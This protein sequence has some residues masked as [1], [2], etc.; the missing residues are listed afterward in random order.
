MT[1]HC[2]GLIG[3]REQKREK[4]KGSNNK[5]IIMKC[6]MYIHNGQYSYDLNPGHLNI[7]FIWISYFLLFGIQMKWLY[8]HMIR[9]TIFSSKYWSCNHMAF[10]VHIHIKTFSKYRTVCRMGVQDSNGWVMWLGG[11]FKYRTF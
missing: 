9:T 1:S 8:N 2:L 5:H 6:K 3:Q 11:P 7:R 10:K 4:T